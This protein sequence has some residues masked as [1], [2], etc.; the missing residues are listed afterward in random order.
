MIFRLDGAGMYAVYMQS[1]PDFDG[2]GH[3]IVIPRRHYMNGRNDL[4][5]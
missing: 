4:C 5:L 2:D 1:L 3:K